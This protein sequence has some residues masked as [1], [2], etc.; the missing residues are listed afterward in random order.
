MASRPFFDPLTPLLY[1]YRVIPTK[2]IDYL[3]KTITL[4]LFC[5]FVFSHN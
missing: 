2:E 5:V 4:F 1:V 3:C